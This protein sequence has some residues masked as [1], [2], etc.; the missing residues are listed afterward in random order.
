MIKEVYIQNFQSHKQT[1][2]SLA[3]GINV[4][5]GSSDSGKTAILRALRWLIWNRP[6]G[7]AFRSNWGGDTS[8]SLRIA[9]DDRDFLITRGKSKSD[10]IYTLDNLEFRAFGTDV[11]EEIANVLNINEIN[12][13]QQLEKPFLL[14]SSPGEIASHFNHI[15]HLDTIDFAISN[16][17]KWTRNAE[18]RIITMQEQKSNLEESLEQY[19]HLDEVER[20]VLATEALEKHRLNLIQ[21]KVN[22]SRLL[23]E[24]QEVER[25]KEIILHWI[26]LE[27]TVTEL[28][29]LKHDHDGLFD[30][31]N[32]LEEINSDISLFSD[33]LGMEKKVNIILERISKVKIYAQQFRQ[34][35]TLI[36][37]IAKT[38]QQYAKIQSLRA[39]YELQFGDLMPD[40]CP[41]C[42]QVIIKDDRK[43]EKN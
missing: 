41:L 26:K 25:K 11:P 20:V 19:A 8:V 24:I 22:V 12:F 35:K 43:N 37:S 5:L 16:I 23:H 34:L 39:D 42:G 1:V 31:L 38:E 32:K 13:Q 7:D 40:Q 9:S 36:K 28:V 30:I 29:K 4:I 14:D 21:W 18:Q 17:Q 33:I 27:R 15:A 3:P 2:L 6:Q 10:N